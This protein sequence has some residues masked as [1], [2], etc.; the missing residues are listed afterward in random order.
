MATPANRPIRQRKN[1][2]H[3]SDDN[4]QTFTTKQRKQDSTADSYIDDSAVILT[5]PSSNKRKRGRPPTGGATPDEI[6][7]QKKS[8]A[9]SSSNNNSRIKTETDSSTATKTNEHKRQTF[10]PV[11]TEHL[12]VLQ[13]TILSH[14]AIIQPLLAPTLF[15]IGGIFVDTPCVLQ[16][17]EP[18]VALPDTTPPIT[19][20]TTNAD[21]CNN[22][23]QDYL[24]CGTAAGTLLLVRIKTVVQVTLLITTAASTRESHC[25]AATYSNSNAIDACAWS[26][27]HVV[28]LTRRELQFLNVRS[29]TS[30]W[31]VPVTSAGPTGELALC[32]DLLVWTLAHN[33]QRPS[34]DY[35]DMDE[36]A[37]LLLLNASEQTIH[38]IEPF[39]AKERW[40]CVSA[41]WEMQTTTP[42]DYSNATMLLLACCGANAGLELLRY[43][44]NQIVDSTS[45]LNVASRAGGVPKDVRLQCRG[46]YIFLLTAKGVRVHDR[47][48]LTYLFAYGETVSL[49]GKSVL[50]RNFFVVPQPNYDA[51]DVRIHKRQ[52]WLECNDVLTRRMDTGE[53]QEFLVVGVPA[54]LREPK[55]LQSTLHIW[56]LGHTSPLTSLQAPRGGLLGIALR[57]DWSVVCVTAEFGVMWE[58]KAAMKTDFA[59]IEYPVGYK[60]IQENTEYIEAEDEL[61]Q[62]V[63]AMH[64]DPNMSDDVDP[65]TPE[66]TLEVLDPELAEALRL[67]LIEQAKLERI[68]EDVVEAEP[69]NVLFDE[70]EFDGTCDVIP[71]R[72]CIPSPQDDDDGDLLHSPQNDSPLRTM[73]GLEIVTAMPQYKKARDEFERR[74]EERETALKE[75]Q[76]ELKTHASQSASAGTSKLKGGKRCRTASVEKLLESVVD[77]ALKHKM[78]DQ[79]RMWADG[80]GSA[81]RTWTSVEKKVPLLPAF[82]QTTTP[83]TEDIPFTTVYTDT[84]RSTATMNCNVFVSKGNSCEST[85][86]NAERSE[87]DRVAGAA[88]ITSKASAEEKELAMELLFL[89]PHVS[90]ANGF[91][92]ALSGK[93]DDVGQSLPPIGRYSD[94]G[95]TKALFSDA[96]VTPSDQS[97]NHLQCSSH[98]NHLQGSNHQ[99]DSKKTVVLDKNCAA[100]RGRMVLHKCGRREKPIDYESI[101]RAEREREEFE[102]AEKL[103]LRV[104]KRREA[105]ARRRET[106]RKRKADEEQEGLE[107]ELQRKEED[108]MRPLESERPERRARGVPFNME[109]VCRDDDESNEYGGSHESHFSHKTASSGASITVPGM[110][111]I[112]DSQ[113]F[114]RP[115]QH[116]P[117]HV[118]VSRSFWSDP[119]WTSDP[120]SATAVEQRSSSLDAGRSQFEHARGLY[121][122]TN[123]SLA[124]SPRGTLK[125]NGTEVKP[126][127]TLSANDAL[128]ALAGLAEAMPS[129]STTFTAQSNSY[130][131]QRSYPEISVNSAS[132]EDASDESH[133]REINTHS[134][135]EAMT[136][137]YDHVSKYY[138]YSASH[139]I[140]H[141]DSL[142]E[143]GNR[144]ADKS[145]ELSDF[146]MPSKLTN[147][148]PLALEKKAQAD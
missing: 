137:A 19:C 140:T 3:Y 56:R 109:T 131:V 147:S 65:L 43:R 50:W 92:G 121:S 60:V 17:P 134:R 5:S 104:Q 96:I 106:R 72:P 119:T 21:D 68:K 46:A 8:K 112:I 27:N 108:E 103:A 70:K 66:K 105:D 45:I 87:I 41:T 91:N 139:T 33:G 64:E 57:N 1:V 4:P 80:T 114:E 24:L 62:P 94:V 15:E 29:N 38:A 36:N 40:T 79:A 128:A 117:M 115:Q 53:S 55:E 124:L 136:P 132:L 85:K 84:G 9:S 49:H 54:P 82:S 12:V 28:A 133:M 142:W 102:E 141:N 120:S 144:N 86:G 13:D 99:S 97:P 135:H 61:D 129:A 122:S 118:P 77:T 78:I 145:D 71:C 37:T 52:S 2:T 32:G 34:L 123:T 76:A 75:L 31:T 47:L 18:V 7:P 42:S 116:L 101:A 93:I 67:S 22:S 138:D 81:P 25:N 11:E 107:G 6:S 73:E 90:I 51:N 63:V 89:G 143:H 111:G 146:A 88:A 59:G 23:N 74:S 48:S 30:V 69:I 98:P 100:C 14:S 35:N 58:W 26:G 44:D 16:P 148:S 39:G 83:F 125:V 110:D 20:V 130:F 113:S 126:S 10:R 95:E 127:T